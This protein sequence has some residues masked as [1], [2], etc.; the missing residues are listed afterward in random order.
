MLVASENNRKH[1]EKSL[2]AHGPSWFLLKPWAY[3]PNPDPPEP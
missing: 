2:A 1:S 3:K